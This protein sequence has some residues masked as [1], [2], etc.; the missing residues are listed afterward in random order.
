[1]VLVRVAPGEFPIGGVPL[2]IGIA[3]DVFGGNLAPSTLEKQPGGRDRCSY[4]AD[5]I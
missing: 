2:G 4:M 3:H 5:Y 1:M